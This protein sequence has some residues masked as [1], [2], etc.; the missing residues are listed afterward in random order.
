MTMNPWLEIPLSDYEAH[1]AAESVG[2]LPVL[3]Q[4]FK[5][6][7]DDFSPERLL[8]LGCGAG[9]GLEH[10]DPA[11]TLYV[12][13]IDI[14]PAYI[15]SLAQR[16]PNPTFKLELE[17]ADA[18][19]VPLSLHSFELVFVALLFEYVDWLRLLPRIAFSL[20]AEGVLV[21]VLQNPSPSSPAVSGTQ[22]ESLLKLEPVFQFV[23]PNVFIELA[24]GCGLNL[25]LLENVPLPLEKSFSI[26]H[27][28]PQL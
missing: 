12:K 16:F 8:V 10:I 14:N 2:Q 23:D 5:K 4:I 26:L 25:N 22:Y 7:L 27:F 13:G 24:A 28:S 21:V 1:M 15:S 17:C 3:N 9:N 20:A 11:V 19:K 18:N 6:A